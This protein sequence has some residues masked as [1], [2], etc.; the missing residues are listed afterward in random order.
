MLEDDESA[1]R[2]LE[3]LHA[4]QLE[5]FLDDGCNYETASLLV[6]AGVDHHDFEQLI[7]R[8]CEPDL[9]ARLLLPI[10]WPRQP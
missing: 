5:C 4:W 7:A 9:A 6:A 2:E 3:K 10:S 8:G 1:E